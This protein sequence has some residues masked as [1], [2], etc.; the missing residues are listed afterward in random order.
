MITW[1]TN[2]FQEALFALIIPGLGFGVLLLMCQI[3]IPTTWMQYKLPLQ[4]AGV[5]LVLFFTFQSGRY[6]EYSAWKQK[7]L[8]AQKEI[9]DLKEKLATE[10]GKIT[11]NTVTKYVDRIKY[12]TQWKEVQIEKFITKDADNK[13]IID[14]DTAAKL[15]VLFAASAKGQLPGTAISP[16]GSASAPK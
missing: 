7:D 4:V 15:R 16:N 6:N 12:V 11:V 9:S 8:V 1:I 3:F 5:V 10:S 13:C 14:P 2:F